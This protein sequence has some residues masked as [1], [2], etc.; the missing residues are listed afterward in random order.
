MKMLNSLMRV[1]NLYIFVHSL[2]TLCIKDTQQM[3]IGHQIVH[4]KYVHL[5]LLIPLPFTQR[6]F[7]FL[8]NS[9]FNHSC[10]L[11]YLPSTVR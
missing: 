11:Y 6:I 2:I 7:H 1:P 10:Q 9:Q 4:I 3:F 8:I 5:F